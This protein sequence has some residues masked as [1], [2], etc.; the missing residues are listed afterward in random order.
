MPILMPV[1]TAAVLKADA[2]KCE[3][4]SLFMDRFAKPG[5]RDSE[6]RD[7]FQKLVGKAPARVSRPLIKTSNDT[8]VIYA[9]LQGRLMVNMA[10][11]VMENA[12]LCLDRFG[13]PYIPGSAVKG[14]ARRMAIQQLL[15]AKSI[16]SKTASLVQ[17][18]LVFG[19][20]EQDWSNVK[21]DGRFISDFAYAVG[22]HDWPAVSEAAKHQLPDTDHFA[23]NTGFLPAPPVDVAQA[24]L[25]L[26]PPA[27]GALELDVVTCHHPEYYQAKRSVAT[28]DEDPNPVIFPAVA[29]GHVFAFAI[30]SLRRC[31]NEHLNQSRNWLADGLAAFGLGAKTA[32]GY[33]W[34][35][36]SSNVSDAVQTA[37]ANRAER[38]AEEARRE[39]EKEAE[40]KAEQERIARKREL[41]Q[42]T[43]SM[44]EEERADFELDQMDSNRQLQWIEKIEQRSDSE[45]LAIYRLLQ[46]RNTA[47][48]KDLRQKAEHGKQKEKKRFGPLVQEMFKIAKQ[49]KEKMP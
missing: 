21:K 3:S 12:G 39:A 17:I 42:I 14:C 48:W 19:W 36:T 29:A 15:E 7:W 37:L 22:Q 47:L 46:S 44:S 43:A 9:Q 5:A 4:R 34:F 16:E 26:Q 8:V 11:G 41:E 33:G 2:S 40:E 49:R 28:D 20:G 27:L 23:G 13:L 24:D 38:E 35:D 18:A 31:S 25:P 30:A 45:K 6:R 1:D 10:G 32:A